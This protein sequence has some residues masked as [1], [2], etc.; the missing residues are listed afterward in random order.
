MDDIY[1]KRTIRDVEFYSKQLAIIT[2]RAKE[3]GLG[4]EHVSVQQAVAK[5][6]AAVREHLAVQEIAEEMG[7][8]SV[9]FA[10]KALSQIKNQPAYDLTALPETFHK[11]PMI[12]LTGKAPSKLSEGFAPM[13][14]RDAER[15]HRVIVPLLLEAWDLAKED[16]ETR[17]QIESGYRNWSAREFE[18][19]LYTFIYDLEEPTLEEQ[20]AEQQ[21]Q[22]AVKFEDWAEK[23]AEARAK[24]RKSK[25]K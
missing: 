14:P 7:Y 18:R 22:R 10:L 9:R 6:D 16:E 8:K 17:E 19:E 2:A 25:R 21:S 13:R 12:W 1:F 5:V 15:Q 4:D 24:E 3:L 11:P 23:N 20:F